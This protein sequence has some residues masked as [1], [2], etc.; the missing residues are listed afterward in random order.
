MAAVMFLQQKMTPSTMDPAQ[1]RVMQFMPLIFS[2]MM[3]SLPSALTL[4][5]FVS[6]FFG[7]LQQYLFLKDKPATTVAVK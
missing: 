3:I 2:L 6:T 4:Y 5:M 1:A 7:I